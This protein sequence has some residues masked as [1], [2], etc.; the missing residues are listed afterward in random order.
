MKSTWINHFPMDAGDIVNFIET[1]FIPE[2]LFAQFALTPLRLVDAVLNTRLGDTLEGLE[3]LL[4][5][6][7]RVI[8]GDFLRSIVRGG[9]TGIVVGLLMTPEAG[10]F[11]NAIGES[12]FES[13]TSIGNLLGGSAK[14]PAQ[15]QAIRTA[16]SLSTGTAS[17]IKTFYIVSGGAQTLFG[18]RV[19]WFKI[20]HLAKDEVFLVQEIRALWRQDVAGTSGEVHVYS[21][22][23]V[24]RG[25]GGDLNPGELYVGPGIAFDFGDTTGTGTFNTN[26]L[27][28]MNMQPIA[29]FANRV[30]AGDISTSQKSML[31]PGN[32]YRPMRSFFVIMHSRGTGD[33]IQDLAITLVGKTVKY[34]FDN[35]FFNT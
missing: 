9:R 4:Q 2:E 24:G 1:G 15:A 34:A 22:R 35:R 16:V 11:F 8:S 29:T 26:K 27:M 19:A 17:D 12:F 30:S 5:E 23:P 31:M 7:G 13:F 18:G 33:S 3:T 21:G 14:N 32:G 10:G 28:F 25:E 6:V 20:E